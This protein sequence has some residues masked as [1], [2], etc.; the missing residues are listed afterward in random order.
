MEERIVLEPGPLRSTGISEGH[1]WL[2]SRDERTKTAR[3]VTFEID[4]NGDIIGNFSEELG[5]E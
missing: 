4:K 5:G 2:T 1:I 3:S